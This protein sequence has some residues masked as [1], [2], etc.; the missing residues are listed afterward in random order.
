MLIKLELGLKSDFFNDLVG[1]WQLRLP[2]VRTGSLAGRTG[3]KFINKIATDLQ[4]SD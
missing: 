3:V 2:S 1:D 4:N